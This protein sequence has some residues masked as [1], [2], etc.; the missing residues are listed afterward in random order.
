MTTFNQAPPDAAATIRQARDLIDQAMQWDTTDQGP[1]FWQD[2]NDALD[3]L[4]DEAEA[5]ATGQAQPANT[6]VSAPPPLHTLGPKKANKSPSLPSLDQLMVGG[7]K[8]RTVLQPPVTGAKEEVVHIM[9]NGAACCGML[10]SFADWPEGH[11]RVGIAE[12]NKATCRV[13]ISRVNEMVNI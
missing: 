10:G 1:D 2:V 5:Q 3:E 6:A 13:C 8:K 12:A 7:S 4:A 11:Y 9:H